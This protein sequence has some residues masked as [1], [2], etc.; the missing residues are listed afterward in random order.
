MAGLLG[1]RERAEA[2]GIGCSGTT[3]QRIVRETVNKIY[4]RYMYMYMYTNI[5]MYR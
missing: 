2:G 3:G 5:Y 1:K 4:Y